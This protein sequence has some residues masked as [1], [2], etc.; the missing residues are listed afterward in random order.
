MIICRKRPHGSM[1]VFKIARNEI[2]F[3][4]INDEYFLPIESPVP[5]IPRNPDFTVP[6]VAGCRCCASVQ[7]FWAVTS[8]VVHSLTFSI[9]PALP[10]IAC[11]FMKAAW[12][13]LTSSFLSFRTVDVTARTVPHAFPIVCGIFSHVVQRWLF[14]C[15]ISATKMG[16]WS[17]VTFWCFWEGWLRHQPVSTKK[18]FW[19]DL[20]IY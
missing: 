13:K 19:T 14:H 5:N 7:V 11:H 9:C 2:W 6:P 18:R 20:I 8:A 12:R 16:R 10:C 15:L 4:V 3:K 1:T 17:P